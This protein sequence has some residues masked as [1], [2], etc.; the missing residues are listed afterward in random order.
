MALSREARERAEDLFFD[1]MESGEDWT[2]GEILRR[3]DGDKA[4]AA[5][6]LELLGASKEASSIM[7]SPDRVDSAPQTEIGPYRLTGELGRGGMGTVYRAERMGD[8]SMEVAIKVLPPGL[9]GTAARARFVAERRMLA[10]LEHPGIARLLDGGWTVDGRPYIVMERVDG[11]AISTHVQ[12]LSVNER[13]K[14]FLQVAAA[15]QYAHSHLIVHRDLKPSNILVS[16]DGRAKLLDFGIAKLLDEE[17]ATEALTRTGER[18][19]TPDYASPEQVR[20]ENVTT[21]SDVYQLGV[22]LYEMLTGVLPF[23]LKGRPLVEVE[24]TLSDTIPKPPS[25]RVGSELD[26]KRTARALRGDLDNIIMKA[27]RKEPEAR[28]ASPEA[29]ASDVQ[30]HLD[31]LP[32]TA[33]GTTTWYLVRKFVRRHSVSVGAATLLVLSLL[34][35]SI[36]AVWQANQIAHERDRVAVERDIARYVNGFMVELF[37][38]AKPEN[39]PSR[40]ISVRD[41]L[42]AGATRIENELE[43]TPAVRAAF[44]NVIGS[45]YGIIGDRAQGKR[46]LQQAL[47]IRTEIDESSLESAE[48]MNDLGVVELRASRFRAAD[49]LLTRALSIRL[50]KEATPVEIATTRI[51][52][53]SVREQQGRFGEADSLYTAALPAFE[54]GIGRSSRSWAIS[55]NNLALLRRSSGR[56]EEAERMLREQL[57]NRRLFAEQDPSLLAL[58]LTNLG[59]VLHERGAAAE[60]EELL[61]EAVSIYSN[62][63]HARP[64]EASARQ[65]LGA[66][67]GAQGKWEEAERELRLALRAREAMYPAA[68]MRIATVRNNIASMWRRANQPEKAEPEF[69]RAVEIA[70]T[71]P[72][73]DWRARSQMEVNWAWT[74]LV[75]GRSAEAGTVFRGIVAAA[76]SGAGVPPRILFDAYWGLGRSNGA[77]GHAEDAE[78]SF[79]SALA[80]TEKV[81]AP[82]DPLAWNLRIQYAEFL[83]GARRGVEARPVLTE[84]VD[85]LEN[86]NSADA[87]KARQLLA[88]LDRG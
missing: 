75:L 9:A 17:E 16:R 50:Q 72:N 6:V 67:L 66:A 5:E 48:T 13:L 8:Y 34:V 39:D 71:N 61:R 83:I 86:A 25:L 22:V 29:M 31:G 20:G 87:V 54:Q 36:I 63:G 78:A 68:D 12:E 74:L 56:R 1:L 84:A 57:P 76:E 41:V 44:M 15:V 40:E 52:L 55:V 23:R 47:A 45:A 51:N 53:A 33:R 4:V 24:R 80:M 28:Y 27:L 88:E 85:S 32:V 35:F 62:Q 69:R 59:T 77:V 21:A 49:S 42:N 3:A 70:R 81:L 19:L 10:R 11:V 46:L 43:Q 18:L 7:P 2:E 79:Q 38:Q 60:A 37:E 30:R 14:L 82:G 58:T 26:G 73:T 64:R 65:N